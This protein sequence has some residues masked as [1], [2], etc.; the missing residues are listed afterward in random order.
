MKLNK[1]IYQTP[2]MSEEKLLEI[3]S[4]HKKFLEKEV[5]K[6]IHKSN[7]LAKD[8]L[9]EWDLI[10]QR[11]SYLSKSQRDSILALVSMALLEMSNGNNNQL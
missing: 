4:K 6:K 1:L 9:N 5:I 7:D 10:E 3:I 11:K 2:E 8:I